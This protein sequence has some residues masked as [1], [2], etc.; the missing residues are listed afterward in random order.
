MQHRLVGQRRGQ[1]RAV[2]LPQDADDPERDQPERTGEQAPRGARGAKLA[3]LRHDLLLHA[4]PFPCVISRKASSRL[5]EPP[6]VIA[7]IEACRT[8]RPR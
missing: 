7:A 4:I 6:A 8:S 2:G 3:E 5:I 1:R